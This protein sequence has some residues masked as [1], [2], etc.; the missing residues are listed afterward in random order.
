MENQTNSNQPLSRQPDNS[1]N[2]SNQNEWEVGRVGWFIVGCLVVVISTVLLLY[3]YS[4]QR[5]FIL[6]ILFVSI[7]TVLPAVMYYV[8]IASRKSSL[9]QEF[10]SNLNRLGLLEYY[11][12]ESGVGG[13]E[14]N[15]KIRYFNKMR[16]LG[17]IKRFEG[18]YAPIGRELRRDLLEAT[19]SVD[20]NQVKFDSSL[21]D[22]D[23]ATGRIFSLSTSIPVFIATI[24]LGLGWVMCLPPWGLKEEERSLLKTLIPRQDPVLYAFLGAY[25]FSLQMLYRRFVTNDLRAKAF[26]SVS[27]RIILAMIGAWILT[28]LFKIGLP[29]I[30]LAESKIDYI[31]Y[32]LAFIIGAFPPVLWRLIR[33]FFSESFA[34]VGKLIPSMQSNLPISDLDGLTV[35]HQSRLEEED[36]ENTYNMANTDIIDL[37]LNTKIPPER[38]IDWID[39]SILYTCI[40]FTDGNSQAIKPNEVKQRLLKQGIR[41]ATQLEKEYA[42][43]FDE[44]LQQQDTDAQNR[45]LYA[46]AR[47]VGNYTN[48]EFVR[49]WR[50]KVELM[51]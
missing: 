46:L 22:R 16:I 42:Q 28:V 38:I 26:V 35:W 10:V 15:D 14:E 13:E 12:A 3:I 18:V 2:K 19:N 44:V 49:N 48:L 21:V 39:Q 23:E 36:V 9:F 37:L 29:G 50:G 33:V 41:T 4:Q 11:K 51:D 5:I 1:D 7:F 24:L 45:Q 17:Y 27:I 8:F 43:T 40:S 34:I 25:F 32:A 20:R 30:E 31:I 6:R 47:A